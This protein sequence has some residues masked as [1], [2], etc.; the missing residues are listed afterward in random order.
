M[1]RVSV[2]GHLGADPELRS[3]QKGLPIV[4][5]RVAVNLARTGANG[6]REEHTE[7]FRVRVMGR[8]TDFAQRLARG[9]RVFVA[10][11]LDMTHYQS[12]EGEPRTGFDVWADEV[13]SLSPRVGDDT[14]RP[15][16][17][18]RPGP[19]Q[20]RDSSSTGAQRAADSRS[21][22]PVDE[23]EDLPF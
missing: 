14:E 12:R 16:P 19:G 22:P 17:G 4:S 10:G 15:A 23:L 9:A 1:I 5:F 7:W 8:Q 11:R 2:L 18:P 3:S 6:E 21:Q 20:H 13:Q